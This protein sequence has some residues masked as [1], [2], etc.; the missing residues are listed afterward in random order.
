MAS[1]WTDATTPAIP[2]GNLSRFIDADPIVDASG[3]IDFNNTFSSENPWVFTS[4]PGF[5]VL[6]DSDRNDPV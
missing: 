1:E 2:T 6:T 5:I 4:G 3:G